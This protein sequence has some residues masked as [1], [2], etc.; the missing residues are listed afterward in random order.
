[1]IFILLMLNI[2]NL[3]PQT[4]KHENKKTN[5]GYT[6]VNIGNKYVHYITLLFNSMF[7]H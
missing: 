4:Q 1:M 7:S 5:V 2:K 3:N 6:F